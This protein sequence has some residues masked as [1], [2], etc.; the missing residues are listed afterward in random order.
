MS[1]ALVW[2]LIRKNN[3]FLHKRGN[4]RRSGAVQFSCEPG[5]VMGVSSFKYSGLANSKTADIST[6]TDAAKRTFL[7]VSSKKY[8]NG[9]FPKKASTTT[10]LKLMKNAP[11]D[12]V[13]GVCMATAA[14]SYYRPDLKNALA[15]KYKKLSRAV[16]VKM[17]LAKKGTSGKGRVSKKSS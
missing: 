11:G 17:N 14:A 3:A 9:K 7:G 8:G 4:T 1:D 15:T 6:S 12:A 13:D 2:S 16:R 5:N 10:T